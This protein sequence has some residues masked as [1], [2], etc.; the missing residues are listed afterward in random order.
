MDVFVYC[1]YDVIITQKRHTILTFVTKIL[2]FVNLKY[3]IDFPKNP[4]VNAM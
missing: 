4:I 3:D 1:F 2:V